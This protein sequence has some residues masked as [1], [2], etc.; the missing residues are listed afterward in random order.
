MLIAQFLF[1]VLRF[2]KGNIDRP[3]IHS[4]QTVLHDGPPGCGTTTLY[5]GLAQKVSICLKELFA[6]SLFSKYFSEA[7]DHLHE[8]LKGKKRTVRRIQITEEEFPF[9]VSNDGGSNISFVAVCQ[10]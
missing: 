3:V 10:G 2:A 5:K 6:S 9:G 4:N 8:E 1:T 7:S